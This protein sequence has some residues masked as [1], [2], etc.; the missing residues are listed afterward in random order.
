MKFKV[1]FEKRET[2]KVNPHT[3]PGFLPKGTFWTMAARLLSL[4]PSRM[5]MAKYLR[6]GSST[7]KEIPKNPTLA[8]F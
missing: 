1:V 8:E 4:P 5:C 3:H 7:E 6:L 2:D